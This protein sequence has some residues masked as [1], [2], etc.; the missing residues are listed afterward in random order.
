MS[1]GGTPEIPMKRRSVFEPSSVVQAVHPFSKGACV[2]GSMIP[3]VANQ[4]QFRDAR[5]VSFRPAALAKYESP[6][7]KTP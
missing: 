6:I 4:L 2:I 7:K 5:T 3:R 1:D